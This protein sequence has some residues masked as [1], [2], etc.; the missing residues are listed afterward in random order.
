MIP[1]YDLLLRPALF[2]L[3]AETAHHLSIAAL[4]SGLSAVVSPHRAAEM[5]AM[6]AGIRF[7]NPVGLAAGYDKDC[8]APDA[9]LHLGFGFVETGT[10]TPVPQEGNPRPRLF[11]LVED[12]GVINR[13]GFNNSGHDA[14]LRRLMARRF[15]RGVV[16]VNI[17]ANKDSADR[18]ADY[19]AG[20]RVFAA[21]ADYL[22]INIS[23][24]NT[25]GLRSLQS[26]EMLEEL[27]DRVMPARPAGVKT[28]IFLKISPDLPD[29]EL[30][31]AVAVALR[32]KVDGLIVSNTTLSR[33]GLRSANAPEA[34]GLSGAPLFHRSTVMLAR[35]RKLVGPDLPLI[36][37][38]GVDSVE[39]ALEKIRAGADLVQ[40]YTG[41]IYRGPGLPQAIVDGLVREVGRRS[42]ASLREIRDEGVDQWSAKPID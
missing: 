41:L 27:L 1:I 32:H 19:E 42:A 29:E 39:T 26:R 18:I 13:F 37:V 9:L 34:G 21:Y 22:A 7:P 11:R 3:D 23:S 40:V 38:G 33:E 5:P 15:R 35:V 16:G 20:V 2:Q 8:E 25:P 31:E 17:G 36:G 24:P 14:F 12:R 30:A 28:P 4:K 10:V 6:V